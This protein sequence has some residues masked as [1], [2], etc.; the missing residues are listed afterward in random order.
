MIC[1]AINDGIIGELWIRKDV[2]DITVVILRYLHSI[3]LN[4]SG[5]T[6]GNARTAEIHGI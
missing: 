1:T 3:N 4:E 2:K 6:T 5:H